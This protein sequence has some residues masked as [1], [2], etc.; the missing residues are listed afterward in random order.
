[1]AKPVCV[2]A[3]VGPGNGAAF[4]RKFAAEGYAVALLARNED[5]LSSLAAGIDDARGYPCDVSQP[6]SI[7]ATLNRVSDEMG[8]VDTLIYN[9][10]SG[11]LGNID[12]VGEA[13]FEDA[14]RVNTLGCLVSSKTVLP[15]MRA[16]GSGNI[17]VIGATAPTS[18][19]SPWQKPRNSVSPNRWRA[20]WA[21]KGSMSATSSSTVLSTHRGRAR[22]N[23]LPSNQTTT[24]CKPTI[25]PM[26]CIT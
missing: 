1:M 25:S 11:V 9:A 14:W 22:W 24:S 7:T 21:P 6:N 8:A 5:Y 16:A 10:G 13:E 15:A 3:G 2:I 19:H 18:L 12:A 4:A 23:P 20:W 26:P 17:I